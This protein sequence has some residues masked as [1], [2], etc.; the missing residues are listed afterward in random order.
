[1]IFF[2]AVCVENEIRLVGGA[3]ESQGRVEICRTEAWNT[4]CDGLWSNEEGAVICKSIGYSRYSEKLD[5]KAYFGNV[6]YQK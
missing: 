5:L 2:I 3:K 1:M 6:I 4:I